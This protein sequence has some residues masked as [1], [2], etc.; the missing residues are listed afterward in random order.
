VWF[1]AKLAWRNI[2]RNKRRT[3][4][5]GTA[6]GVGLAALIFMDALM[7]GMKTNMIRSA[8]AA[9]SGEGQ[10]HRRGF[11]TTE[12][13]EMTINDAGEVLAALGR[14]PAVEAFTRR[15]VSF[16]MIASPANLSSIMLVGVDPETEPRLSQVRA[17]L[18][19]GSFLANAA[20]GD[21]VIGSELA[22]L[23]DASLGERVVIT[24]A[25]A[26]TDALAQDLFRVSGI[27]SFN[28]K[29]MDRGFAFV[30][31][32]KA[33]KML[34]IDGGIHE[35]ALKFKS[36]GFATQK[37]NPFW[38]RYSAHGN[39]AVSWT[40]LFPQLKTVS[41]MLWVSIVFMAVV[42]FGI[43]AFGIINTLF[44]SLYERMFEFGVIRAIGTRPGGVRRL[45]ISEAAAL[46]VLSISM[47]AIL[48]FV[49][50]FAVSKIGIDYRGIE[51]AGT[52]FYDLLY[53]ELRPGQFLIYPAAVFLF[54]VLVG[55]YPAFSAARMR[56]AEA[57]RKSL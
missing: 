55:L 47:G 14:E 6:I 7:Q 51:F 50:T 25:Q 13:I 21:I 2:F 38:A 49:V 10:I 31:L 40:V 26:N 3:I 48:G 19:K 32:D 43:V 29:E 56:V 45:I 57:L 16:G 22:D 12:Q 37:D 53:P 24:V 5:A 11:R 46:A 23:L 18:K 35:I 44:M 28:I 9:Y 4:I 36:I 33:Q 52:T 54:T 39:E 42:L 27:Y 20:E 8:T 1:T 17:N 41:T 15:V 34:A 30:R